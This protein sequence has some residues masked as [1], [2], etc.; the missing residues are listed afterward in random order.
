MDGSSL[1]SQS[2]SESDSPPQKNFQTQGP[3]SP[4]HVKPPRNTEE[5]ENALSGGEDQVTMI[6]E[7]MSVTSAD[8][9]KLLLLNRNT[10]LR[11]INKELMKLNE[12]WDHMYRGTTMALQQRISDLEQECVAI[13]HLNSRL[14]LKVEHEQSKR[15]YCERTLL[16]E[17]KKN[18]HLQEYIRL[19]ENRLHHSDVCR[20]W[21]GVALNGLEVAQ[22]PDIEC[23]PEPSQRLYQES[24]RSSPFLPGTSPVANT[25][26]P[27]GKSALWREPDREAATQ[28]EMQNLKEQ[29]EA[30]RCQTQ[31]YEADYKTEHKDHKRMLLENKKLRRKEAEMRQQMALLHEQLKVYEDDFRKERSD[32]QVLQRL[33]MKRSVPQDPILV[34]RCNSDHKPPA[35]LDRERPREKDRKGPGRCG[36]HCERHGH[37]AECL[38]NA[39]AQHH[40]EVQGSPFSEDYN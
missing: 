34:H 15:E 35:P 7:S 10:E 18:Q 2:L 31:I 26:A 24:G 20:D 8:E 22:P 16:Q 12:D 3:I 14:L 39:C 19:L 9:E 27:V 38:R 25:R 40:I 13:K 5:A 29:L 4:V 21:T 33:L 23:P 30:L 32:K 28:K 36:K 1:S 11:R 17:L 6:T 37:N